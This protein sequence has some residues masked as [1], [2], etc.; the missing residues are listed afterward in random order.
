M[1]PNTPRCLRRRRAMKR[2]LPL[3]DLSSTRALS[4]TFMRMLRSLMSSCCMSAMYMHSTF[5]M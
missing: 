1:K 2:L 3:A 5:R 4:K